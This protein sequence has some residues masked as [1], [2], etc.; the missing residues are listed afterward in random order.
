MGLIKTKHTVQPETPSVESMGGFRRLFCKRVCP[1]RAAAIYKQ[2]RKTNRGRRP[3][4]S[5][6]RL[7][8]SLVYHVLQGRGTFAASVEVVTGEQFSESDLS[9]RRRKLPWPWIERVAELFLKPRADPERHPDAFYKGMRKVSADGATWS[10]CNL[11]AILKKLPKVIS[12]RAKAAFSKIGCVTLM[13]T[14]LHNPIAIVVGQD[15]ESEQRLALRIADQLCQGML[16]LGDRL[17]ASAAIIS[18]LLDRKCLHGVE[19]L[20][21]VSSNPKPRLIEVLKDG[22]ALVEIKFGKER[23]VVREIRGSVQGRNGKWTILRLWTSL[24]DCTRYPA[25][26][27]LELYGQRWE[28]EIAYKELKRQLRGNALL[29][30]HTVETGAQ[31][32]LALVMAQSMVSEVRQ[33]VAKRTKCPVLQA[34]FAKALHAIRGFWQVVA[35]AEGIADRKQLRKLLVRLLKSL[36]GQLTG[37]RRARSCTRA[38]RQPVTK[39]PRL[40]ETSQAKGEFVYRLEPITA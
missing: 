27:L 34:S 4:L 36:G 26:E 8:M 9:E 1:N 23:L 11:P 6:F 20:V 38:V 10:L 33:L 31:E 3:G 14:G 7:L 18:K 24:L 5:P 35:L 19:F 16:F 28:H 17:Y 37:N 39:W 15:G 12:R 30:S 32:I 2:E 25:R 22:T 40:L 13:E 21:R 29:W